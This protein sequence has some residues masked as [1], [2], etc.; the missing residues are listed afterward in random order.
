MSL[1]TS[2]FPRVLFVLPSTIV[3]GAEIRLLNMLPRLSRVTP[4]LLTHRC[5]AE[6]I[7]EN[8]EVHWY[9]SAPECVNPHDFGWRNSLRYARATAR[10][11]KTIPHEAVFGWLHTGSIFVALAR[12]FFGLSGPSVGNILGPV[13]EHYRYQGLRP[14]LSVSLLLWLTFRTHE[15]IIVPTQGTGEDIVTH[16]KA[17]LDRIRPI[18]NGIPLA[19]VREK[20]SEPLPDEALPPGPF[21]LAASRLTL[22]KAFDVQLK[23]FALVRKSHPDLHFVIL[24]EGPL[25]GLIEEHIERLSLQGAVWLKGFEN[26]PF[27]WMKRARVF[28]MASRMEGFGNAL[29]EAMALGCPVVSTACPYGPREIVEH[30]INGLLSP[31]DDVDALAQNLIQILDEP[32][33]ANCLGKAAVQR[34]QGFSVEIMT[35]RYEETLVAMIVKTAH[36]PT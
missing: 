27:R 2:S 25:H 21:I 32:E 13:F 19:H 28:M 26:N 4:V 33:K 1:L 11:A 29:V 12:R 17:P 3:G 30:E 15:N 5:F 36:A 9:E 31:V 10:L 22:E 20:A 6:R 23:A 14:G 7:P 35:K 24:G 8:I 16:F 18:H 34:A